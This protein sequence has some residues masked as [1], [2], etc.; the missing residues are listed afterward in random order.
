MRVWLAGL[1][2]FAE[3]VLCFTRRPTSEETA[4]ADVFVQIGPVN[5]LASANQAPVRAFR[6]S[7]MREAGIPEQR[8]AHG[9]PVDEVDHE[10]VIGDGHALR[11]RRAQLTL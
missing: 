6:W 1:E 9:S 11:Q 2:P 3:R 4:N 10:R 5:A 7:A 8:H